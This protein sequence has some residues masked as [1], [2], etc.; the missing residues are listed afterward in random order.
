VL[1]HCGWFFDF[2]YN[3]GFRVYVCVGI[4][5]VGLT[6][7]SKSG[8]S[9]VVGINRYWNWDKQCWTGPPTTSTSP[10]HCVSDI[11]PHI[12]TPSHGLKLVPD[13]LS[14]NLAKL[15]SLASIVTCN[16]WL[17][18]HNV[19]VH[20]VQLDEK[21]FLVTVSSFATIG[22]ILETASNPLRGI[23]SVLKVHYVWKEIDQNFFKNHGYISKPWPGHSTICVLIPFSVTHRHDDGLI[24]IKRV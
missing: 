2:C 14:P 24:I 10:L 17:L 16:H 8:M 5:F 12:G 6:W 18:H 13:L 3:L 7:I 9:G 22:Q 11:L 4:C 23:R 20:Q 15:D 19:G 21:P 1:G